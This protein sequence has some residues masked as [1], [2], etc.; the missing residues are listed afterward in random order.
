M[1]LLVC[2]LAG[3]IAASAATVTFND[4]IAPIVYAKCAGCHRPGESGPFSLTSYQEVAKRGSLIAAVTAKRYMPPW[5]AEPAAV[6]YRDERRLPDAQIALIQEWVKQGMPEGDPKKRPSLP[7]FPAGWQL[8]KPDLVLTLPQ[9]YRIPAAGPDIYRDFVIP[10]GLPEDKWIRA[11][12]VRPTAPKAVHHMLYYGDPTGSLRST[13]GASGVPGFA[14]LGLPRGTFGLGSWGAGTQPHFLPEGVARPFPKGSDLIIQEHFHPI[15]KEELEKTVVGIYFAPEAPER[16]MLSVQLP[17]DFGLFAG[18]KIP[19][20]EKAYTVRD[21][22]TLP[23]DVDA[24]AV[25]AHAHYL[26]KSMKLTATLPSGESKTLLSVKDWDFAWQDSYIFSDF[27]TLPKGARLDGEVTWDN[28]AANPHNPSSPPVNIEWGEQSR[29]EMGSV[30]LEMV[31]HRQAERN[32]LAAALQQRVRD[33]SA[34][35]YQREP[36]FED[37]VRAMFSGNSPVFKAGEPKR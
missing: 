23:I 19:A 11:I 27:T 7:D 29:D 28:S 37:R 12:E 33:A 14:G 36:G 31:P 24:F 20:G 2:V 4:Q 35:A 18:I 32:T 25:S 15:G 8:G 21:S 5:H 34:A 22:F 9:A 6:N 26:G 13:D 30:T 1:K 10:V 3:A 16:R 17:T